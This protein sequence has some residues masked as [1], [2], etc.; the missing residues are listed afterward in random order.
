[1]RGFG[2]ILINTGVY[3]LYI[4][5]ETEIKSQAPWV[6]SACKLYVNWAYT[7]PSNIKLKTKPTSF[8]K[9]KNLKKI[10]INQAQLFNN[11]VKLYLYYLVRNIGKQNYD[12]RRD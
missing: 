7:G 11:D 10:K 12:S 6:M 8:Y 9:K 5:L 3:F 2:K 4:I 1:M